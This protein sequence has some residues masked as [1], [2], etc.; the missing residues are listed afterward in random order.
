MKKFSFSL[1]KV[2]AVR[3]LRK[4]IA[5]EKLAAA[6][7]DMHRTETALNEARAVERTNEARLR[8]QLAGNL[9]LQEVNI[10]LNF[11]KAVDHEIIKR[12]EELTQKQSLAQRVQEEV[13]ARN[14]DM[15]VLHRLR[16]K[17]KLRY[18]KRYRWEHSKQMDQIGAL[19]FNREE[20]RR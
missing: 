9:D 4:L 19:Y 16:E 6:L 13:I 10:L 3:E 5:E 12:K 17:Q 20:T 7:N 1:E 8:Q 15:K 14:Q 2:L 11:R 18:K